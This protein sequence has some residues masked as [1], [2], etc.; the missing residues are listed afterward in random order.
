MVLV[1]TE[2]FLAKVGEFYGAAAGGAE[3]KAP[4]KGTVAIS[5][6][7]GACLAPFSASEDGPKD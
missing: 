5:C 2:T 3:A 7:S 4:A 6:K 1:S